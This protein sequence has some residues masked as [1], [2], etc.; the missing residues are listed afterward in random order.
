MAANPSA[1][2]SFSREC[3]KLR[4]KVQVATK[5]TSFRSTK[6][7]ASTRSDLLR[8]IKTPLRIRTL[9]TCTIQSRTKISTRLR[10]TLIVLTTLSK[11]RLLQREI[12]QRLTASASLSKSRCSTQAKPRSSSQL[13]SL[14][15]ICRE[16]I[17]W[18]FRPKLIFNFQT[19]L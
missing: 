8:G 9:E 11:F 15:L 4:N 17:T 10:K 19:T 14:Q 2:N 16:M 1:T 7:S 13:K 12:A 5:R 3:S 18:K 6:R